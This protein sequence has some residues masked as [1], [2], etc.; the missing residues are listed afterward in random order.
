MGAQPPRQRHSNA[1]PEEARGLNER[2]GDRAASARA[3]ARLQAGGKGRAA[4]CDIAPVVSS[5]GMSCCLIQH[6]GD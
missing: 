4:L 1:V 5:N 3:P 6:V 2:D